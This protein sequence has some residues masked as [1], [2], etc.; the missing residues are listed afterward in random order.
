[1]KAVEEYDLDINRCI[2]IGDRIRDLSICEVTDARGYL[3]G[4]N[5]DNEIRQ[6]AKAGAFKNISYAKDLSMAVRMIMDMIKTK[7]GVNL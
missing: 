3:I 2:A 1:M 7:Q 6:K 4:V 5:E